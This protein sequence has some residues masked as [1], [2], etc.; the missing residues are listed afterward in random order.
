MKRAEKRA[1][2]S[3]SARDSGIMELLVGSE[4]RRVKEDPVFSYARKIKTACSSAGTRRKK[5]D[6][7]FEEHGRIRDIQ[8]LGIPV[9]RDDPGQYAQQSPR[10]DEFYGLREVLSVSAD[11]DLLT[12]KREYLVNL[13]NVIGSCMQLIDGTGEL[14]WSFCSQPYIRGTAISIPR[15]TVRAAAATT[16]APTVC[17][18]TGTAATSTISGST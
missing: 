13:E 10:L 7:H 2:S 14:R 15:R 1:G 8:I 9:R 3:T 5:M 16:S 12:G 4:N 17:S 6:I 11:G 18:S